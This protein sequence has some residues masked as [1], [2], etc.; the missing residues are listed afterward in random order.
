MPPEHREVKSFLRGLT[1]VVGESA[2]KPGSQTSESTTLLVASN[3]V[4]SHL[5]SLVQRLAYG[6]KSTEAGRGEEWLS[7]FC[8]S[9]SKDQEAST[10]SA[11]N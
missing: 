10:V 1:A 8:G 4:C 9:D 11:E 6:L 3:P 5:G 7:L 2:L